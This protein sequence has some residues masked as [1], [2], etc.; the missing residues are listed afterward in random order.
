MDEWTTDTNMKAGMAFAGESH[1]NGDSYT[2]VNFI[3]EEI[4]SYIALYIIQDLNHSPQ[5][6]QKF[7]TQVEDE[8]HGNNLIAATMGEGA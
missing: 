7:K 2:F 6:S 4:E 5:L 8:I 3:P 1:H